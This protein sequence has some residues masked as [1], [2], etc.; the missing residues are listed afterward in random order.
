MG[1]KKNDQQYD[2]L[3]SLIEKEMQEI[4]TTLDGV[5]AANAK[6]ELIAS[7]QSFVELLIDRKPGSIL[8]EMSE[9]ELREKCAEIKENVKYGIPKYTWVRFD[10]KVQYFEKQ[11]KFLG[12]VLVKLCLF[13]EEETRYLVVRNESR[14]NVQFFID[15][16]TSEAFLLFLDDKNNTRFIRIKEFYL[17]SVVK[18]EMKHVGFMTSF[19]WFL[20]KMTYS[21]IQ[22]ISMVPI[23]NLLLS[24][25]YKECWKKENEKNTGGDLNG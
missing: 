10:T 23:I 2:Y 15:G 25:W 19:S 1:K 9:E 21:N 18:E 14:M 22:A 6:G 24:D 7:N 3:W 8:S 5:R 16:V 4:D 17:I 13:D 20:G 12:D 11:K